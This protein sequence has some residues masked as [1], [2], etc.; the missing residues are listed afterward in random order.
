[1]VRGGW[2]SGA[3]PSLTNNYAQHNLRIMS[4]NKHNGINGQFMSHF[5]WLYSPFCWLYRLSMSYVLQGCCQ[6]FG[7]G[8]LNKPHHTTV[9]TILAI[10]CSTNSTNELAMWGIGAVK[11]YV[12]FTCT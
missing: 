10:S 1:M 2:G 8:W 6:D 9:N 11:E 3:R 5:K 7:R 4:T 12:H